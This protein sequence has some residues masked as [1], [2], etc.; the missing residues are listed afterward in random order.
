M[1]PA[2]YRWDGRLRTIKGGKIT[3]RPCG[4]NSN[5]VYCHASV[6][7]MSSTPCFVLLPPL[8]SRFTPPL[9]E[10]ICPGIATECVNTWKGVWPLSYEVTRVQQRW[11]GEARG[12]SR[13]LIFVLGCRRRDRVQK[14]CGFL[15]PRAIS[16][17]SA[18]R[19]FYYR[20]STWGLFG[21]KT[22]ARHI[23]SAR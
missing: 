6:P 18:A 10:T 22:R 23:V 4:C 11:W 17:E 1:K 12:S 5:A 14:S 13:G 3:E 9:P 15:S 21:L 16:P 19:L 20:V 8:P 2:L 7:P